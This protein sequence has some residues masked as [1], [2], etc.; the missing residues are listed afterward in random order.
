MT[1]S[2]NFTS[3][4]GDIV[5]V[6]TFPFSLWLLTLSDIIRVA[7]HLTHKINSKSKI[8]TGVHSLWQ[9]SLFT[10]KN[11]AWVRAFCLILKS[12]GGKCLRT[13]VILES[14][15]L[16]LWQEDFLEV[17]V[18]PPEDSCPRVTSCLVRWASTCPYPLSE[19]T[20]VKV[21]IQPT[22][23]SAFAQVVSGSAT[24]LGGLRTTWFPVVPGML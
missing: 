12:E 22:T 24:G 23:G 19:V 9:C 11:F 14:C 6:L 3:Y 20:W 13:N 4:P 5:T 2:K 16:H 17:L 1:A 7:K 18:A 8:S 10:G 15:E 21:G